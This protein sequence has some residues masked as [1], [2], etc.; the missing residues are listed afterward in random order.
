VPS[1]IRHV[2]DRLGPPALLALAGAPHASPRAVLE[3]ATVAAL[4]ALIAEAGGPAWDEAG[5]ARLRAHVAGALAARTVQV[6]ADVVRVLDARAR[7]R[8]GWSRS[9]PLPR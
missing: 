9:P 4:E 3:D 8:P 5:F 6:V 7:S 1:P 2:Q